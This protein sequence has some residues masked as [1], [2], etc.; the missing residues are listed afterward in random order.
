MSLAINVGVN[1]YANHVNNQNNRTTG[2][3][4][5]QNSN[6]SAQA[7][8]VDISDEARLLSPTGAI[9]NVRPSTITE[10]VW[11]AMSQENRERLLN[12]QEEVQ[13]AISNEP[14]M[15]AASRIRE[16]FIFTQALHM[17]YDPEARSAG[18]SGNLTANG[19]LADEL[20]RLA[21]GGGT[22]VTLPETLPEHIGTPPTT[23]PDFS[24]L[25][26]AN[27]SQSGLLEMF[28][29]MNNVEPNANNAASDSI[30]QILNTHNLT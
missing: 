21:S 10:N 18:E 19:R 2:N 20:E 11:S 14:M 17:H 8:L 3:T 24:G 27:Q 26:L 29:S 1:P 13:H 30:M 4:D 25:E 5:T 15:N 9:N 28:N 7:V 12:S 16:H 6:P 23:V 22:A